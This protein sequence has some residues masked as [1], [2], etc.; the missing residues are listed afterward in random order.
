MLAHVTRRL[1]LAIPLLVVIS[2]LVFALIH[3]APGGPLAMYLENPN[4]RPEDIVRL[5][6]ALGLDRSL[7]VQYVSWLRGFVVGEW[8]YSFSDGRPVAQR[9]AERVP[10]TLELMSV[11]LLLAALAAIPAGIVSAVRR[12]RATDRAVGALSLAGISLPVF[13]FG[14]V[15]QLVFAV[16]LGWLPS[17]GR[18]AILRGDLADRVRHLVLPAAMLATVHAAAWS[19]YVRAGMLEALGQR[20][21]VAVRAKGVPER[22]V[23]ARHAL[24]NA[25]LP[26]LTVV[27]LD[28]AIMVSG[29]VVTESVFAWPGLGGL[30]TEALA[31]RDYTVLMAFLMLSSV[32][33]I[34][35]NL[36][37]DVTYCWLDPRVST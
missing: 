36:L 4:V 15:L 31:R 7:A 23:V 21:I 25:L 33:V 29:A 37:A 32:A 3:A 27:L 9:L 20:F 6:K 16:S 14:L 10:A 18:T 12:G 24:R 34:L 28:A 17:S 5:K 26:F 2:A 1:L 8:G 13:W 35:L 22:A 11:S 30:F 19:R